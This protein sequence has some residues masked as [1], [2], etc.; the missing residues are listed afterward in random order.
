[1]DTNHKDPKQPEISESTESNLES[2]IAKRLSELSDLAT[3]SNKVFEAANASIHPVK[4]FGKA[5]SLAFCGMAKMKEVENNVTGLDEKWAKDALEQARSLGSNF[6]LMTKLCAKNSLLY[7]AFEELFDAQLV[8]EGDRKNTWLFSIW[9]SDI[10][11][12]S[13]ESIR[14]KAFKLFAIRNDG[15]V[16]VSDM[17][18]FQMA[19]LAN[20]REKIREIQEPYRRTAL[21][22]HFEEAY[23]QSDDE[24][25]PAW[26]RVASERFDKSGHT[27][28]KEFMFEMFFEEF[29]D[30]IQSMTLPIPSDIP[31][32]YGTEEVPLDEKVIHLHYFLRDTHLYVAEYCPERRLFFG[33]TILAGDLQMAEWG[34]TSLDDEFFS[35]DIH[36]LKAERDLSW[37]AKP[38]G[39]IE[40]YEE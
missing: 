37:E 11:A 5:S 24:Q 28:L 38:F 2:Q 18:A 8:A 35:L 19:Y 7:P 22:P 21:R 25:Q 15:L 16:D 20:E 14:G 9:D 26:K 39:Q 34:Y 27:D 32:L 4:T 40:V 1:M 10:N 33:Y 23:A 13:E 29:E 6:A 31:D 3:K 30:A 12:V 17:D 36:G